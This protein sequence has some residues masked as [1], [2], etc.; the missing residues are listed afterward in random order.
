M[1]VSSDDVSY[2]FNIYMGEGSFKI[3]FLSINETFLENFIG[4][5]N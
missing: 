4:Y 5:F 3:W 2:D 1:L